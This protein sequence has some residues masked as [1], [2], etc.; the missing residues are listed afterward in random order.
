MPGWQTPDGTW[1]VLT[2]RGGQNHWFRI[3]HD[4]DVIDALSAESMATIM[5]A[6]GIDRRTLINNP[7][8]WRRVL[9]CSR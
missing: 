1:L 4:D 6:A 9:R 8:P 7:P 3:L 2:V 5:D